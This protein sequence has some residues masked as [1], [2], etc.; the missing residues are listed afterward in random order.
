MY[1]DLWSILGH[2]VQAIELHL[3]S[4]CKLNVMTFALLVKFDQRG[5][6]YVEWTKDVE[7]RA[8][9]CKGPFGVVNEK[10]LRTGRSTKNLKKNE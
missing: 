9:N 2:S 3:T 8:S 1:I 6:N 7:A 5:D 10:R 4:F